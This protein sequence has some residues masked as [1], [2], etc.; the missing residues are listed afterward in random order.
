[1]TTERLEP[2]ERYPDRTHA[3]LAR[4]RLKAGGINAWVEADDVGGQYPGLEARRGARLFVETA[5]RAAARLVL[6]AD[7]G[8]S[9]DFELAPNEIGA[10]ITEAA[11]AA[12]SRP[13]T[14]PLGLVAVFLVVVAAIAWLVTQ[15]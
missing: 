4:L 1:M 13:S 5:D 7:P 3:E 9:E 14:S 11:E 12:V 6:D 10:D 8:V 2:I 15:R